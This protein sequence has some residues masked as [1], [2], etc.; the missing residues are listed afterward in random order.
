MKYYDFEIIHGDHVI[1]AERRV[2][3]DDS[4]GAWPKVVGMASALEAPG[5]LIRV[6]EHHGDII[7]LVGAAAARR[8]PALGRISQDFNGRYATVCAP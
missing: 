5:Y 8:Y 7:I 3:L 6:R 4:D 2:A 1:V